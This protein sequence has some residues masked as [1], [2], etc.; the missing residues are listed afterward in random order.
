MRVRAFVRVHLEGMQR[1]SF[2]GLQA[3][4]T[5]DLPAEMQRAREAIVV[6]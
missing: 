1:L 3:L 2:C 6:Q 4:Q 5:P